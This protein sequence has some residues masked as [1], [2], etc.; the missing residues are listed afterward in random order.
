MIAPTHMVL[1]LLRPVL[2][3]LGQDLFCVVIFYIFFWITR[4]LAFFSRVIFLVWGI[5]SCSAIFVQHL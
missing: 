4:L 2:I 1:W 3:S 5:L